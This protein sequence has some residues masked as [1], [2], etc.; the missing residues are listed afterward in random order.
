MPAFSG[1]RRRFLYGEVCALGAQLERLLAD[2][3]LDLVLVVVL[4]DLSNNPRR[5][6]L[7][8]LQFLGVRDDGRIEFPVHNKARIPRWPR[9][10]H[11]LNIMLHIRRKL[12]IEAGPKVWRYIARLNNVE[13]PRAPLS[14]ETTAM[15]RKYFSHDV[16]LLGR[17]LGN[18]LSYWLAP[19]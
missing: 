13:T 10:S 12:G 11:P 6:Y 14:P 9:L 18:D 7:R 1:L 4:D 5:E 17:L 19:K 8:V 16:E 15:L 3:P 2:V